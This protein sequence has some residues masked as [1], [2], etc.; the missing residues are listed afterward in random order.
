[1]EP[2]RRDPRHLPPDR[3]VTS[4]LGVAVASLLLA[5]LVGLG[6]VRSDD[7]SDPAKGPTTTSTT[8]LAL[9][10][11][12]GPKSP[13]N[14]VQAA[15]QRTTTASTARW[16]QVFIGTSEE[17]EVHG[18][19][20]DTGGRTGRRIVLDTAFM[21][22]SGLAPA[23][24]SEERPH[25]ATVVE[26]RTIW[27]ATPYGAPEIGSWVQAPSRLVGQS[28]PLFRAGAYS[29]PADLEPAGGVPLHP[30]LEA[31][32]ATFVGDG[33]DGRRFDLELPGSAVA[34]W[35][36]CNQVV[37][38]TGLDPDALNELVP[39][40]STASLTIGPDGTVVSVR[41]DL[42]PVVGDVVSGTAAADPLQVL[43]VTFTSI[44][45]GIPVT[46]ERPSGTYQLG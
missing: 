14:E 41:I 2:G 26:G 6:V 35:F 40:S 29:T 36:P 18:E 45:V 25:Y 17:W 21:D 8:L 38:K 24:G 10:D 19:W 28:E 15:V 33:P 5:G 7:S 3:L 13:L 31:T 42:E 11:L 27:V 46:V 43:S 4:A 34:Y 22:A 16:L 1:M 44:E 30:L 9:P 23:E 32:S 12:D 37:A 20:D 39:S